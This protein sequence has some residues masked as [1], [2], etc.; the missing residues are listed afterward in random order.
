MPALVQRTR[1]RA[2]MKN[3]RLTL[4]NIPYVIWMA[5]FVVIPIV[6]IVKFFQRKLGK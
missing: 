1:R 4:F 2:R 6:E 5:L 3:K